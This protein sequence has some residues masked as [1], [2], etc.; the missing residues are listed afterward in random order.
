MRAIKIP[1]PFLFWGAQATSLQLPAACRQYFG[2]FTPR[3]K[4]GL[5]K[6]P[7]LTGWQPVLPGNH[8]HA[9]PQSVALVLDARKQW[10]W[11]PNNMPIRQTAP[12]RILE[13]KSFFFPA[14]LHLPIQ[15]IENPMRCS[16]QYR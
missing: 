6:L 5:G 3:L 8:A 14:Q 15:L 13:A 4:P 16:R 9:A 11:F 1:L 7:R 2:A 12:L 10:D